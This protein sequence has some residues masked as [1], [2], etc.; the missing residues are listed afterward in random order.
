MTGAMVKLFTSWKVS[1]GGSSSSSSAD[2]SSVS[3][4]P[5]QALTYK[6]RR[7]IKMA[8]ALEQS[9]TS[10]RKVTTHL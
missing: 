1:T 2:P 8:Y 9:S 3:R 10:K 7:M 5:T 6:L 4:G